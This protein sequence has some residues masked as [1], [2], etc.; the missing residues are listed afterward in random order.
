MPDTKSTFST[1]D[2]SLLTDVNGGSG[3]RRCHHR[4]KTVNI[5]NNYVGAPAADPAPASSGFAV[6]VS[7]GYQQA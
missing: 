2:S 1:I 3:R 7:A 4:S 5:V 6:S